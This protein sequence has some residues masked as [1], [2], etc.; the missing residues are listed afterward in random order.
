MKDSNNDIL[1]YNIDGK[2]KVNVIMQNENIWL[3]QAQN[4]VKSIKKRS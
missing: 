2:P 3:N 4:K 1:I